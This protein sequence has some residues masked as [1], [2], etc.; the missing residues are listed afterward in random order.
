MKYL[1]KNKFISII[2]V[3]FFIITLFSLIEMISIESRYLNQS[4]ITFKVNNIRNPQI[5]K[6]V[7][8][9]DNI[10]GRI[11]FS[12][13]R[14]QK[15]NFVVN[16]DFY[17]NLPNKIYVE[18]ISNNYTNSNNKNE[19]NSNEWHRS[20]GNHSSNRFSN[21]NKINLNNIDNLD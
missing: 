15:E 4:T 8:F 10:Y 3:L 7:R 13:S 14:K 5:K 20:H 19:N 11:Y 21:L 16:K 2:F 12:L 17:N 9:I 18:G 1:K 6:L